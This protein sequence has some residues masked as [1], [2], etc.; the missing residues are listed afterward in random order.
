MK[1]EY[2]FNHNIEKV[3]KVIEDSARAEAFEQT[4]QEFDSLKGVEYENNNM[5]YTIRECSIDTG[6]I[7]DIKEDENTSYTLNIAFE[8]LEDDK[9]N[10]IYENIY[11]SKSAIK[12]LNYKISSFVFKSRIKKRYNSFINYIETMIEEG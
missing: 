6:Y 7:I 5:K 12:K 10:L 3:F 1:N 9:T 4:K 2:I 11:K 8:S